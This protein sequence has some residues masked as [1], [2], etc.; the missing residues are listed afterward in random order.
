MS[1]EA[2]LPE[3]D[4]I[5]GHPH[6]RETR[7]LFGQDAAEQGFL[8]AWAE[9]R[10]HHAWLLRGPRGIGKATLAYRIARALIAEGPGGPQGGGL[11]GPSVPE[12][13]NPPEGCPIAARIRAQGEPRLAVLRRTTS[14]RTGRLRS[15]ISVDDVR[16]IRRFFS[17]SAAD[18]GWRAVIVDAADEMNVNAAN[19]L[20]KVLEEPP[21]RAAL[22][23]VAHSPGALL[24]TIRSRCRTL[25]LRP[26]G[27]EALAAALAGAGA[28]VSDKEAGPLAILAGGSVGEALRVS[29]GGGVALYERLIALHGGGRGIE[30]AGMVELAESVAGRGAETLYELVSRLTLTLLGRLARHAA[31]QSGDATASPGEAALMAAVARSPAQAAVWAEA[32]ARIAASISHARAVNLD[33]GQTIIDTFLDIDTTLAQ[34]RAAA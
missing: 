23:L 22:L 7:R 3:P 1:G 6:P 31:T 21:A 19:A 11:F 20:L 34:A 8:S 32:A 5:P 17:L 25:D 2:E 29:A 13:L 10:L 12:T 14:E 27:P 16:S 18:G 30:R 26:L 24:P 15:Q 4:R 9:G 28:P 33:P